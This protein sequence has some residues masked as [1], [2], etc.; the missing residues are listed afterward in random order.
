MPTGWEVNRYLWATLLLV[1]LYVPYAAAAGHL[2]VTLGWAL[3]L[4]GLAILNAALRTYCAWRRH[5]FNEGSRGWAFNIVD[6]TLISAGVRITGGHESDL[7]LLFFVLLVSE[8]L[9]A[10]S[11]DILVLLALLV[12]AYIAGAWPGLSSVAAWGSVTARLGFLGVAGAMARQISVAREQRNGDLLRLQEEVSAR[13]ERARIAR[14]VHDGLGHALVQSILRLELC[15]RLI[16]RDAVQAESIL[17][18][19]VP[20]IRAAWN[21][22]RDLAF[23]LRPW[24]PDPAGFVE[25]LRRHVGRFA[26]RTSLA[27]D[28]HTSQEHVDLPPEVELAVVRIVQEAL[29]NV[30]RHAR[31]QRVIVRVAAVPGRL[32]VTVTDD[33]A[34]FEAAG[35]GGTGLT[36]MRE[37]AEKLGGS[38]AVRSRPGGGTTVEVEVSVR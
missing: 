38:L 11:R 4:L 5:G 18:E 13:E 17:R 25:G 36:S 22:G 33:G 31:A 28:F 9:Y 3:A 20:A 14:E 1:C 27:V 15:L 21:E 29:T 12:A 26:E 7:W 30:A 6:I 19:E 10:T 32:R 8:A 35:P 34:G 24:E 16:S 37:R 23:H 2:T